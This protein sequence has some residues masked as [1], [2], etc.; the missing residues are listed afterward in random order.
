M[1]PR[2]LASLDFSPSQPLLQALAMLFTLVV[3]RGHIH[4][5]SYIFFLRRFYLF[6]RQFFFFQQFTAVGTN[7][8]ICLVNIFF[9]LLH[10]IVSLAFHFALP[11]SAHATRAPFF[12]PPQLQSL[13]SRS[14][15]SSVRPNFLPQH[16]QL[17]TIVV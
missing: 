6:F 1:I 14:A 8:S 2:S 13:F 7:Q 10:S 9:T 3:A 11:A 12:S 16:G 4:T 17:R 5:G 15:V